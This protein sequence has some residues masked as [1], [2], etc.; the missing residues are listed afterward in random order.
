MLC[1]LLYAKYFTYFYEKYY[2]V[3]KR[4]QRSFWQFWLAIALP[5]LEQG[6]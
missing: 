2:L 5:V 1:Q 3:V 6:L 4:E